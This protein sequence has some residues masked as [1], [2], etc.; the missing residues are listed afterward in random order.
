MPLADG[1]L[2]TVPGQPADY[3]PGVLASLL[4]L[5]DV[6]ETGYHADPVAEVTKGTRSPWSVTARWAC[7]R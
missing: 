7:A 1:T 6:M 2:V 4:S 3:S 5:S